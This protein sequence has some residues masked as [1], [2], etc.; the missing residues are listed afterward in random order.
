MFDAVQASLRWLIYKLQIL[1]EARIINI[2]EKVLRIVL[3]GVLKTVCVIVAAFPHDRNGRQQ[4]LFISIGVKVVSHIS[5]GKS[6]ERY[7]F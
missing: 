3:I 4:L 1:E 5:F 7:F 6:L 2:N